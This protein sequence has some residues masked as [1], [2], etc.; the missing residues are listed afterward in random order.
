MEV[1]D[2]SL[3]LR[4]Q[5]KQCTLGSAPGESLGPQKNYSDSNNTAIV[6][7]VTH[8]TNT[9]LFTGDAE[10]ESE[11]DM[12]DAGDNLD[13]TLWKVG[14]HGS[15]SSTSYRFLREIMPTYAI[16]SVGKGNSYGH[17]SDE[18]MSRLRDADVTVYRTDELGHIV[19]VSD[20]TSLSINP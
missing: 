9:V 6:L 16:I 12:M 3:T 11:S 18:V 2:K 10:R 19:V 1:H 8:G 15:N 5:G 13:S 14:H 4:T 17:P 7:K 20:G